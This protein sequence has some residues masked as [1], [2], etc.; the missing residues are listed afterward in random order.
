LPG[1]ERSH[2]DISGADQIGMEAV[3]TD[4]ADKQQALPRTVGISGMAA[5]RASLARVVGVYPDRSTA[6][7]EGFIGEHAVQL[8]K[9]PFGMGGVGF[10][11]LFA[12]SLAFAPSQT[13]ADIG[14]VFQP[15]QAA[16]ITDH[17]V[18]GD[19]MIGVGFQPSLPSSYLPQAARGRPGAFLLQTL[20]Q[21]RVMVGFGDKALPAMETRPSPGITGDSQEADADVHPDD[22]GLR[23]GRRVGHLHLKG[24]QQIELL[25][26]LVVPEFGRADRRP[27]L[28][29]RRVLSM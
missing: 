13:F 18:C 4:L 27:L 2:R 22:A 23:V 16:G 15:D 24:D 14:Q 12:R 5:P 3:M 26:G 19:D 8:C 28:Q 25:L 21:S 10:P 1:K 17:D 7:Q 6:M 11:L 9:T 20:S 29:K